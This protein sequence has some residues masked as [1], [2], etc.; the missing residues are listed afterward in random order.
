ML[1]PWIDSQLALGAVAVLAVGV[2]VALGRTARRAARASRRRGGL[3]LSWE[4]LLHLSPVALLT[5]V[6]PVVSDRI[7]SVQVDGVGLGT[8]VLTASLTVPWLSQAVCMPLYRGVGSLAEGADVDALRARFC[9]VWPQLAVRGLPVV[10]VFAVP[11]QLVLGWPLGALGAYVAMCVLQL[12][13]AQSL[14][15]SNMQ[16]HRW[17][18]AAA[19]AAYALVLLLVPQ[20]WAL[21]PLAGLLTQLVPMRRHLRHLRGAVV[22]DPRDVRA[23]LLRGLLVGAVL[24]ADKLVFFLAA[25]RGFA[26]DTVFLA[27]LPA[28]LAYNVYFVVLAPAFDTAVTAL[29]TAMESAPLHQLTRHSR[30]MAD[31]VRDCIARTAVAGAALGLACASLVAVFEPRAVHLTVAVGVASWLFMMTTVVCYKLDYV[32]RRVIVQV[33]GALHLAATVVAFVVLP[34]GPIVYAVLIGVESLLLA[35]ALRS[36]LDHWRRPEYT[37]F[38]R[39]ATAW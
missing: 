4:L 26:V 19:W 39:H 31:V 22:V 28:V 12:L 5:L 10:A 24:W 33:V 23:D 2:V 8:I 6:F 25:G 30:S 36:C 7:G 21:P 34:S 29:R 11:V 35:V 16:G 38:W 32:G 13:F 27:L 17:S 3:R 15:L 1:V 14:V 20:L 9:A 18:W 37:L